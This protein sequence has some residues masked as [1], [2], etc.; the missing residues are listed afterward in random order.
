MEINILMAIQQ[1]HTPFL[2]L[3]FSHITLLGDRG[4]I[5][6]LAGIIF[7]CIKKYRKQGL[8]LLLSLLLCFLV[9]NVFLKNFVAR[10]RPC[11][12]YPEIEL[13]IKYPQDF[14]FPSGHTMTGMAGAACVYLTDKKLGIPAIILA[15]IIAFSRLYLFVHWPSDVLIG[16][17]IGI[18]V[19]FL[20]FALAGRLKWTAGDTQRMQ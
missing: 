5:W 16:G 15:V 9:G 12:L 11:W 19:A 20:V 7:L 17:L 4:F 2:N 10:D 3:F 1:W 6:I 18:A 8:L 14:S 13:L